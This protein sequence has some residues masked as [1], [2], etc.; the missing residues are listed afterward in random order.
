YR[1]EKMTLH[2]ERPNPEQIILSGLNENSDSVYIVLDR[3]KRQFP[4]FDINRDGTAANSSPA[5][6]HTR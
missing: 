3:I 6:I 2:Y 4:L 5:T 1:N